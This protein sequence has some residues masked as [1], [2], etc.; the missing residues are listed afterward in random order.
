[1]GKFNHDLFWNWVREQSKYN[2]VIVSEY[3]APNDFVCIWQSESL[4][5]NLKGKGTKTS[6]EKLFIDPIWLKEYDLKA[7]EEKKEEKDNEP[8]TLFNAQN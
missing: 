6:I 4:K 8:Q 7:W 3:E 5:S 1:M 2:P